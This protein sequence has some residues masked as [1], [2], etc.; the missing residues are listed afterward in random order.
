MDH[1]AAALPDCPANRSARGEPSANGEAVRRFP[2]NAVDSRE[3]HAPRG[4][5][6]VDGANNKV[7]SALLPIWADWAAVSSIPAANRQ[8][9]GEGESGDRLSISLSNA[10]IVLL[11]FGRLCVLNNGLGTNS[12]GSTRVPTVESVPSLPGP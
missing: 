1:L 9:G 8:G 12:L 2:L 10:G 6:W 3:S 5:R 11:G 4:V 7:S